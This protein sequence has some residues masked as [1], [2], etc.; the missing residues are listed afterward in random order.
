MT[1]QLIKTK[2]IEANLFAYQSHLQFLFFLALKF[3]GAWQGF[4]KWRKTSTTTRWRQFHLFK[5]IVICINFCSDWHERAKPTCQVENA[6]PAEPRNHETTH[7]HSNSSTQGRSHHIRNELG[8]VHWRDP[9][10][11]HGVNCRPWCWKFE[12]VSKNIL[13]NKNF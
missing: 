7:W 10:S 6:R 1:Q 11:C 3:S 5:Y 2:L 8:T 13:L 4:R 9:H 12:K